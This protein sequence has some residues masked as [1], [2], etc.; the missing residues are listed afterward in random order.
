VPNNILA[1]KYEKRG[2]ADEKNVSLMTN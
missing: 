2:Q 1:Y